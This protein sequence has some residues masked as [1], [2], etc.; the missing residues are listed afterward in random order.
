MSLQFIFGNS[1]S[2]KSDFLYDSVLKQAKENKEQQ[3]LIIVPEQ[4]TMQ[5]QREL[6]ERQKQHAIMNV[7]VLSFARLA[8]RVFDD[9]GK[10]NVV[11]L[12]ETGKNLVLRKVAE[13][14]KAE[15]NVLGANMNKMGYV[16]EVKSLIS[17][18][19]QYNIRPDALAEF[20]EKEPL[21]EGLRLKMQ[22]VLTMYQGFTEYLKGRYITAEEV[23]EL[24]Y[25]VAEESK[26][27]CGSVIVLDEF[28]G[29]TPIQNRL[30]EKLFVL[31]K[32]VSVSVT[33][34]VREDFYQCRGVHELFAMSKKTVASLLKVAEL[35]KV[36]V[37]EPIV[38]PTGEK[39]RYAGAPDLYFMEQNL[40]RPGAGS[41]RYKVSEKAMR[42]NENH[43][44]LTDSQLE[45]TPDIRITSLKNPREELK[46]A[47]CEI[48]R[49]TREQGYRYRD[50]AVVTGDVQ[51]YGNYVP[52]IFEQ[53]HIP[54]FID[55]TKNILF[56]PFIEC[57]RAILEMIEYDF[58]YESV[59]RF[60]RCG[61]AEKIIPQG[62][63]STMELELDGETGEKSAQCKEQTIH[64]LTEQEIDRLENYVL[65]RGIRGASRWSKPWTFVMPD[66]TLE[67][68]ERLN[69]I[70]E[71]V[72]ENFK[73]LLMDFRGKE[74]TVSTQ[75]FELYSLIRR[76]DMEQ[77]LKERG[78]F[79][80]KN[81]N[82][83]RAKE[84]DQIYKIVM[85]L[86]DKVTSL[87]GDETMTIREYS[88]ILDAG[89]EA[90][91]VGIIPPGNDTVTVGDIERTRLNHIKILFFV[92]VNDGVVPKAGNQGGIISQFERE[93]MAEYHLEL[94]P[95]AREKVFIQKFYLY[96]N[97]TK[98]SERLY[99][100]F[101]RV[102][103]DGKA[104][105]RSYL[106]GTLLKLFPQLVVEEPSEEETLEGVLTAESAL[107]FLMEGLNKPVEDEEAWT[108]LLAWYLSD[109]GDREKALQL[110]DAAFG[111]H[112][113]DAISKAVTKALYGNTLDNSVTRLE[114]F[115]AC[116]FAH[117]LSYGLRLRERELQQFASVDMGNIYHD[118]LERFA[119]GIEMS[120]YTWFDIPQEAQDALLSQSMEDAIAGSGIGDVFEDARNS[121]LLKRMETTAKR[122]IWALMLQ[123]RK[124]KF[125]PSGFEVSFSR[126]E[127]L[128]AVQFQLGED[129]KMRLRGR[130]DRIDTYETDD[131]VY[132]KIIDY[133]SGN[134]SFSLLNF[135][136]GLQLQ[137]VVYMNVALELTKKIYKGKDTEPA[138]IF[139]YHITDPMVDS[140]G[141][142]SE[143]EIR[144]S[145][146][147]Q[148]KVG[149][150]VNEDPEIYGAMDTDFTGTSSVIPVALKADG[151][152]KAAS[153]TASA[154][155]F[156]LMSDYVRKKIEHVGKEIF[157]GN[158][159]VKPYLLGD[160]SG[161]DYCPYHTICGFD[162]RMPGFSYQQFE[163][164]D[165]SEEILA[166]IREEVED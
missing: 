93:K 60:L 52:E 85:D 38:L 16:G 56:H 44:K 141:G 32:K 65:A 137:L 46:F 27:L 33:M 8:Y 84:Y 5:T 103:S 28:T 10:Q 109:E 158:V 134:T 125:V 119:K 49:L 144:R 126:A 11:V 35:C 55:Q 64:R 29:F 165:S 89:F 72:Y 31:A 12:E 135:Y 80:E 116:A 156:G 71:A 34:D 62:K 92:G 133:K 58:S 94:A 104:L 4:F 13:Q 39:R 101:C 50:I 57:I 150:L 161:C 63:L 122:T 163:K 59:F 130:I 102:N 95:G 123:V 112:Q 127:R 22:D 131:K 79:F 151:S 66:G 162:V 7:D 48:V 6:V 24:L 81:G 157:A 107:P 147:E 129:E 124:G 25:D 2:G 51:Q 74:N 75:T 153:K 139:Y 78:E 17:E 86:L 88:D 142:E 20:L 98:P 121:Y 115:A 128:D 118:V 132:V 73:P 145:I 96:L 67:D 61:L 40:F 100:T 42:S 45:E 91:K 3:F 15:L 54:Y 146:L 108:A 117:Y 30:M 19:M 21:G 83:A 155:E 9:L 36:P 41:Y 152:L 159:S 149:G 106:I 136:Y 113:D 114:Q 43:E 76:L 164:F 160:R 110:F 82:Q 68:M 148:L 90:A 53:Y 26:L 37:E 99:V 154:Y 47:A 14:K 120:E 105:R 111:V 1:G 23:L 140:D 166:H 97:M 143:E 87:L 18:L 70:R 69:E 138:G 77:L